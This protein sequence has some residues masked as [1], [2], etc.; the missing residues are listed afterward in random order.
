MNVNA[1]NY[2]VTN[3]SLYNRYPAFSKSS[4]DKDIVSDKASESTDSVVYDKGSEKVM[5]GGKEYV[6]GEDKKVNIE[7][8]ADIFDMRA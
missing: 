8:G 3:N 1:N 7:Y 5:I 4:G 6:L 2:N